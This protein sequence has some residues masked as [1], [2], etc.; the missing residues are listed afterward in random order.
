MSRHDFQNGPARVS[1]G[2][3][4]PL[5]TFFLQVW[6]G[7]EKDED[8]GP[9]I[10]LGGFYGEAPHPDPLILVA[11]RHVPDLPATL[12]RQ[13]TIDRLAAPPQPRRPGLVDPPR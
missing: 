11:R 13:L 6:T 4:A 7:E 9:S 12:H 8:E 5:A 10:W 1:I 3:D 2:W